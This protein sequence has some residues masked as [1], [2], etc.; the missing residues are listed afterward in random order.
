FEREKLVGS[1]I[2]KKMSYLNYSTLALFGANLLLTYLLPL[3]KSIVLGG[4][5]LALLVNIA[6]WVT[7]LKMHQKYLSSHFFYF[8]LYLCALEIAP[9][10]II[11]FVLNS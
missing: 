1:L 4:I 6:G 8:I 2:F 10:V 5:F 7:I 11:S 3:S 9:L